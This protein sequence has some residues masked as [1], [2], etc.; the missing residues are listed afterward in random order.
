MSQIL[1][2]QTGDNQATVEVQFDGDTVWLNLNQIA[3]LLGRD[4]SVISRQVKNIFS[5]RGYRF[6]QNPYFLPKTIH[7]SKLIKS[8]F[9]TF[10]IIK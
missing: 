10:Q 9:P 3:M 7:N 6:V 2:Y 8:N 5:E 4:K 1:I